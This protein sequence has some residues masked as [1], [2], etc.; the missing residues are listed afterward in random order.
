MRRLLRVGNK[1]PIERNL[2]LRNFLHRQDC[3]HYGNERAI[4]EDQAWRAPSRELRPETNRLPQKGHN[5]LC[6]LFAG[7]CG[8]TE[9]S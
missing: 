1:G 8:T 5:Q 4:K 3:V 2:V 9:A 7:S 6:V